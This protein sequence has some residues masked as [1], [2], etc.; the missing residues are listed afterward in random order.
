M[1]LDI[2]GGEFQKNIFI[3]G[4]TFSSTLDFIEYYQNFQPGNIFISGNTI[5]WFRILGGKYK[6]VSIQDN[7]I[8]KIIIVEQRSHFLNNDFANGIKK[9]GFIENLI[10][11]LNENTEIQIEY[12]EVKKISFKGTLNN[13]QVNANFLKA[14]KLEFNSLTKFASAIFNF[15]RLEPLN[16]ESAI[17]IIDSYLGNTSF[18]NCDF[19]KFNHFYISSS[20]LIDLLFINTTWPKKFEIAYANQSTIGKIDISK[21]NTIEDYKQLREIYRQLKLAT[22]KQSDKLQESI[23]YR[24][25]MFY[26][27]KTLLWKEHLW[28]KLSLLGSLI[29]N[30]HKQNWFYPICWMVGFNFLFTIGLQKSLFHDFQWNIFFVLL[31]PT[32]FF[33]SLCI[34]QSFINLL[35]DFSSR[36]SNGFLIY[37]IIKAFR[38]LY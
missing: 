19:K 17:Y 10:F 37:Q 9:W 34:P 11:S 21:S 8:E 35:I 1:D 26:L 22:S 7:K 28:T 23:F 3:N 38:R 24:N 4:S 36:I 13:N 6:Y 20:S 18:F 12:Q 5:K 29:S 25:E 31:N 14:E 16:K 32:H 15:Y 30:N 33:D 27:N 2:R